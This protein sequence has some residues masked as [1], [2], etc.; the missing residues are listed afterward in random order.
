MATGFGL[1][2]QV[3][4]VRVPLG[5]K[6]FF[7]HIGQSG[8][9]AHSVSYRIHTWVNWPG[10]EAGPSTPTNGKAKITRIYTFTAPSSSWCN[11]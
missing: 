5:A 1:C 7:F 8:T 11:A 2:G 10:R 9:V 3:V 4:G 6:G